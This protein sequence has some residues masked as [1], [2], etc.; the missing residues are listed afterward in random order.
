VAPPCEDE[1]LGLLLAGVAVGDRLVV[2]VALGVWLFAV[3]VVD[4]PVFVSADCFLCVVAAECLACL[5]AGCFV[6]YEGI[7]GEAELVLA[8]VAAAETFALVF[9]PLPPQAAAPKA[10]RSEPTTAA[11]TLLV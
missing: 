2:R 9:D 10:S 8:V 4:V 7:T 3:V 6:P 11:R 5:D 1:P